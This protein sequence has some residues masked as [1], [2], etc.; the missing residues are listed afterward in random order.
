[1]SLFYITDN[2]I[3]DQ[4]NAASVSISDFCQQPKINKI[5]E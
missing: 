4:T 3:F 5:T 2:I 1:M